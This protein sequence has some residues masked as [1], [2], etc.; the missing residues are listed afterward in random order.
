MI[1]KR[2]IAS[3]ALTIILTACLVHAKPS[4]T[5]KGMDVTQQIRHE[6]ATLPYTGIWDWIEAELRPDGTVVLRGDVTKPSVKSDLESRMRSLETVT[7]VI[8]DIRVLPLSQFDNQIRLGVYRS[9]FNW[10]SAL[11]RYALGANPS[12]HIIVDNG[13]VTLKGIVSNAMD[14]Q[15]AGI[16]ANK[17]FGVF[18]VDNELQVESKLPS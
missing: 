10:N 4:G 16:D 14:K 2:N 3:V 17:V 15:I 1:R 7:N 13:R 8:D 5:T 9:L 12:I 6:I 18:A 11:S